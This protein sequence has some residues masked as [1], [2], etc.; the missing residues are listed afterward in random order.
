[1]VDAIPDERDRDDA[2]VSPERRNSPLE[3]GLDVLEYLADHGPSTVKSIGTQLDVSRSALYRI[4]DALRLRG[5]VEDA[6]QAGLWRIGPAIA[7]ISL[8]SAHTSDVIRI[9]PVY[10]SVLAEQSRASVGL[11]LPHG[12]DMVFVY[13]ERGEAPPTAV[14]DVGARRPMHCTAVGKAYLG[15]LGRERRAEMV[16]RMVLS[17]RTPQTLTTPSALLEDV[18][19]A[20]QR[21]WSVEVREIDEMTAC[22]GAPVLD[23]RG[24]VVA[25][26]S[27]SISAARGPVALSVAGVL[28][29]GTA[30]AMSRRLGYSAR[31]ERGEFPPER[32]DYARRP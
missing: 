17:R 23:H 29:A 22:V 15:G 2:D 21:G 27:A 10:L 32:M 18:A 5:Y 14:A 9:A 26:I 31:P 3:R 30:E 11:A 13:R 24:D 1:M 4:L 7:K 6:P 12:S 16:S 8:A 25:A 28:T 20:V 19:R